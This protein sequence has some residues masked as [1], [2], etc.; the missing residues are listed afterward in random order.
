VVGEISVMDRAVK[1]EVVRG[2]DARSSIA[3]A[4][5]RACVETR[6]KDSRAIVATVSLVAVAHSKDTLPAIHAVAGAR[7]LIRTVVTGVSLVAQ[8]LTTIAETMTR[9]VAEARKVGMAINAVVVKL[10]LAT[11]GRGG[12]VC[13]QLT[14]AVTGA[15][16]TAFAQVLNFATGTSPSVITI[17]DTE[18]VRGHTD[19]M[20]RTVCRLAQLNIT[21][22][23]GPPILTHTISSGLHT[24]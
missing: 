12:V 23:S 17:A 16:G 13:A 14:S 1:P 11:H 3:L 19:T 22:G 10:A 24:A 18:L 21:Q 20:V 2:T 6:R 8:T 15:Q 7:N 4:D 9:A 5:T